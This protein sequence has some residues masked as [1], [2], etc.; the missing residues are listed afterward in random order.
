MVKSLYWLSQGFVGAKESQVKVLPK[1]VKGD[2]PFGLQ[3]IN[4]MHLS[5]TPHA[6]L[7]L[8]EDGK[9]RRFHASCVLAYMV[10]LE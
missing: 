6:P 7:M 4:L 10:L 9:R 1:D 8:P 2:A 3:L 5:F